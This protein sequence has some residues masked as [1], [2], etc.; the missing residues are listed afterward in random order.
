MVK[1]LKTKFISPSINNKSKSYQTVSPIRWTFVFV[2]SSLARPLTPG[3]AHA[4]RS[5]FSKW[6]TGQ[7]E[8]SKNQSDSATNTQH[9]PLL[10]KVISRR[11]DTKLYDVEVT[12][13]D[14]PNKRL[15]IHYI[16]YS[17]RFDEW[18]PF[19]DGEASEYFPFVRKESLFISSKTSLEDRT[20]SFYCQ[21]FHEIKK[22]LWS[23]K[24]EDPDINIDHNV[25]QDVFMEGLGCVLPGVIHRGKIVYRLQSNRL[26][27]SYLGMKW[28]ERILNPAGD[29]AYVIPGTVKYWLGQR[30]P[31]TEYKIIGEQYIKSEVETATLLIFSL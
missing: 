10:K 17:T 15:K 24:R 21:L 14:K 29:C 5:K 1:T 16:G 27:D 4:L 23:G 20:Q 28:D 2:G 13:V 22:R 12:E 26:L 18:R 8:K 11:K 25:D 31:S 3:N 7:R 6:R 30:S 9:T 19:G